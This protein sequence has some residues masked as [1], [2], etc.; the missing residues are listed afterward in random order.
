MSHEGEFAG[1][2][3][4]RQRSRLALAVLIV[5]LI[6]LFAAIT[7]SPFSIQGPGPVVDALG[8]FESSDGEVMVITVDGAETFDSQGQLNVLSVALY[9]NP[10]NRLTWLEVAGAAFDPSREIIP[11]SSLYPEGVTVEDRTEASALMMQSSQQLAVAAALQELGEPIDSRLVIVD[12]R[13]DGAAAG[14][15]EADDEV[16]AINGVTV[17]HL[18][19]FSEQMTTALA[20][21]STLELTVTRGAHAHTVT[22]EPRAIEPGGELLLGVSIAFEYVFPY[23]VE[24]QLG[25]IGGPSAGMMF[26]LAVYEK[27][28]PGSFVSDLVV[29]GSGTV[30]SQGNIGR[31]GSLHQKLWGAA[32]VDTELFL[33]SVANCPDLPSSIPGDFV[34]APV[35]T[36]SEAIDAIERVAAGE[37]VPGIERCKN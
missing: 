31:I 16:T 17:A 18:G 25:D 15:L 2:N 7:P 26:A 37:S 5:A 36:L 33:M 30:D 19:D 20:T 6:W 28:T 27:L 12:V 29:S 9:G 8:S 24:L 35:A 4:P 10:D 21:A 23:E 11:T 22:V 32:E 34:L 13:A 14:L 3:K 1:A